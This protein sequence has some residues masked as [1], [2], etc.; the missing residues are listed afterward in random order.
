MSAP[1]PPK[2]ELHIHIEGTLEPELIFE[3]AAA[4]RRRAA[5][6]RRRGAAR[7]PTPSPTCSRFLDIYYAGMAVLR[8]AAGLPGD[9]PWPTS[10]APRP[11][12]VRHVEM[13]F[14]PQA[15]TERGVP[16]ADGD[17]RASRA[18]LRRA[19]G[20]LGH[21]APAHPVL[22]ARPCRRRSRP[23]DRSTQRCR[24][25]DTRSSASGWT[26][27]SSATRRSKFRE[28]F[29]HARDNGLHLVAHAGEEGPAEYIVRGARRAEGRAHRPRHPL[30]RGSCAWCSGW[31]PSG[32]R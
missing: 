19:A 22:P 18:G 13:F 26:P 3:L 25:R 1:S 5:V 32:C 2:A 6:R 15:H 27:R 23:G 14:D 9:R 4:Q 12:G 24:R 16:L 7:A 17:R 28:V 10:R 20:E 29:A 31:W 30:P 11:T 8:T 21:R